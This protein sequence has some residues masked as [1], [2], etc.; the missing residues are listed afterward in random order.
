VEGALVVAV[1][2]SAASAANAVVESRPSASATAE[3]L[4]DATPSLLPG[5]TQS[6][7]TEEQIGWRCASALALLFSEPRANQSP[8]FWAQ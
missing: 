8:V 2:A 4:P 1:V 7:A 3:G 5:G 6:S